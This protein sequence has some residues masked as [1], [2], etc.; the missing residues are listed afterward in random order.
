MIILSRRLFV[1][2]FPFRS[3]AKVTCASVIMG[4]AVYPVGNS[5]TSMNLL[6][7]ILGVCSGALIYFILLFLLRE[8]QPK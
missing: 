7:L 6:N 8:F 3:L 4:I 2:K 5:L 1:W